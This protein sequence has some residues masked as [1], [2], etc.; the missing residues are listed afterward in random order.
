MFLLRN[1]ISSLFT[2]HVL[3]HTPFVHVLIISCLSVLSAEQKK[4][5]TPIFVS[6]S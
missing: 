4:I 1:N 5:D 6:S 2:Y 3:Q